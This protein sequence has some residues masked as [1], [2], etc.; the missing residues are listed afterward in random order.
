MTTA[1]V[2]GAGRGRRL[3]PLTEDVPKCYAEV[4][5][6]RIIDW[7]VEALGGAGLGE[8]VFVG[9]Y[10]ID[11]IRADYPCFSFRHNAD[12]PNNNIAASLFHA[13]DAM[14]D[15]FVCSYAD[16][17][18]RSSIVARLLE[19][20]ADVA[21]AV[22]TGWRTRYAGR[23]QHPEDD[24]EKVLVEDER[25]VRIARSIPSAEAHGEFIGVAR[26]TPAG[27]A[28]LREHYHRHEA[29][30]KKAYLIELLQKMIEAGVRVEKVDTAGD[31]FEVD[32]TEDYLLAQQQWR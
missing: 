26:F 20:R 4:G 31:Y 21:V 32:T 27:A 8:I 24:A 3:M 12:W 1:I 13:E 15:G 9:G 7:V 16:I 22:D 14:A 10:Q 25:V 30:L 18:Y 29:A 2:V 11:R 5:G 6:R 17:L 28:A 23:S 19:S